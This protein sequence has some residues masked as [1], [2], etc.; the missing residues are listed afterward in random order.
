M[1]AALTHSSNEAFQQMTDEIV[2]A[3]ETIRCPECGHVQSAQVTWR[4]GAPFETYLHECV[5]CGHWIHEQEWQ[6]VEG[7]SHDEAED[8]DVRG[9]LLSL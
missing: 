5:S 4:V 8:L 9:G 3:T 2:L 7:G 1:R 6:V